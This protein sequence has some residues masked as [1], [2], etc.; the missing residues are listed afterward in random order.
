[1]AT[2]ALTDMAIRSA[3]P[4]DRP[5]KITDGQSLHLLVSVTGA[6][7]WRMR[8]VVDGREKLLSFG[9]YPAVSLADA[10]A[11]RD[12]AKKDLQE[13]RDPGESAKRR[14]V[15]Q[16]ADHAFEVLARQWYETSKGMWSEVHAKDVIT[17]L[18][19]D[20]FPT[21]GR[22]SVQDIKPHDVLAVL[23]T[24]EARP[25]IET[26]HRVGQRIS[27]VFEFAAGMGIVETNPAPI[28]LAMNWMGMAAGGCRLPLVGLEPESQAK[29]RKAMFDMGLLR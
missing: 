11:K 6:R 3:K 16:D 8:Y 9:Q 17:S 10:R 2:G 25:A 18:E 7:L 26:A 22:T 13:G 5:Y 4:K 27:R 24:I 23:R 1:M 12:L 20:V 29:L 28:K 15:H 21:L 14:R 19:N